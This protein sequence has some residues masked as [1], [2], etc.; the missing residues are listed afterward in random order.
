MTTIRRDV[1]NSNCGSTRLIAAACSSC[2]RRRR[3]TKTSRSSSSTER[4]VTS[5]SSPRYSTGGRTVVAQ[6]FYVE[7]S[8]WLVESV[9]VPGIVLD[10]HGD[11]H[12]VLRRQLASLFLPIRRPIRR[13]C[14]WEDPGHVT[15]Q[16]YVTLT[17]AMFVSRPASGNSL[18]L[19]LYE[20]R[21]NDLIDLGL[22]NGGRSL[23]VSGDYAIW[24]GSRSGTCCQAS[25]YLRE[26]SHRFDHHARGQ[27]R[28]RR[29]RRGR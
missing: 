26:S 6:R 1:S 13:R 28:Q 2:Q 23:R 5:F 15:E 21:N 11:A 20:W 3:S 9:R 14:C 27:R 17:G 16:G 7:T 29:Q 19:R 4:R 12:A 8:P 25:L 22:P 24:S 10:E 18:N